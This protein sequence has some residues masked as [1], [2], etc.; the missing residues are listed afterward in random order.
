MPYS[1]S[2]GHPLLD[3]GDSV[4]AIGPRADIITG[5]KNIM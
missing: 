4:Q 3:I 5:Q 2:T 1:H